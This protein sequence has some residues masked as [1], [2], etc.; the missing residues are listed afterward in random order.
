MFI[1]HSYFYLTPKHQHMDSPFTEHCFS[2]CIYAFNRRTIS[3]CFAKS[4]RTGIYILH[5]SNGEY[6][7]GQAKDVVRRYDQHRMKH[8]DIEYISF[9]KTKIRE[10]NELERQTLKIL[11][12]QKRVLRNISLASILRGNTDLDEVV[13]PEDQ[14]KWTREELGWESEET[15]R[16]EYP[17]QRRKYTGNF[18][19]LKLLQYYNLA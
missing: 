19:G 15:T 5:F 14:E 6:Y 7:V 8:L 4:S 17:E 9:K 1:T 10:L 18:Q 16:F 13:S 12:N 3:D 11:E 2:K